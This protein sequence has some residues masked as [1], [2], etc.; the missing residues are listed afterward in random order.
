MVNI[1]GDIRTVGDGWTV[2]LQ[3]PRDETEYILAVALNDQAIATSGDYERYFRADK[4]AHHIINPKTGRS[5]AS[6]ISASIV[7]DTAMDADALATTVFVMG[8]QMG[9]GLIEQLDE[10]E[11]LVIDTQRSVV[12]STGFNW[13]STGENVKIARNPYTK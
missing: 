12:A 1:G 4:R 3:D 13:I 9:L 10:V 8:P 2:A 7:A 11:G 5:A 6:L